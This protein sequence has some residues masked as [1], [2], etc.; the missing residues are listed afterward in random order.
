[1]FVVIAV[2]LFLQLTAAVLALRLVKVT[3]MRI[4]WISIAIGLSLMAWRRVVVFEDLY[5]GRVLPE[6]IAFPEIVAVILSA[7]LCLG[8]ATIGP[9]FASLEENYNLRL[10]SERKYRAVADLTYD[11]EYWLD[12]NLEYVY[13]SPS[14]ARICGY[15]SSEIMKDPKLMDQII[16]GES[17]DAYKLSLTNILET[18]KP[19][20]DLLQ[21]Y[22]KD[23]QV[24]FVRHIALPALI[25]GEFCGIRGSFTDITEARKAKE[26]VVKLNQELEQRVGFRTQQLQ[27]ANQ[28]LEAFVYSVSHDLRAPL[29][30]LDGYSKAITEDYSDRIDAEGLM[31]LSRISTAASEM[32][33]LID[34][35]LRLSKIARKDLN[36]E[37]VNASEIAS[38]VVNECKA[39]MPERV[40]TTQIEP[41]IWM[42]ADR[43]LLQNVLQNLI[44]NSIKFSAKKDQSIIQI[45]SNKD[46]NYLGFTIIDNGVGFYEKDKDKLFKIFSRLHSDSEYHGTGVGLATIA[47]IVQRHEGKIWAE[48][49]QGISTQ[50]HLQMP[51][52]DK[53]GLETPDGV[54]NNV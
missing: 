13:V 41:N 16:A 39:S 47:R 26:E 1:M 27:E 25:D 22:N 54:A 14:C 19:I 15:A 48:S 45:C 53:L 18:R 7:F 50:F 4:G 8:V 21:V 32:N 35:L 23:R 46:S 24:R 11:W 10:Q 36:K 12:T 44:E 51:M 9:Y 42:F 52:P 6:Q 43:A 30:H 38:L 31:M 3:R 2:S 34:G 28:D 37:W 5:T 40:L 49:E 17:V 33:S 29:R 20:N